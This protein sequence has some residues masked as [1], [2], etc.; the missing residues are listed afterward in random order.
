M[1]RPFLAL[2]HNAA[3]VMTALGMATCLIIW[4]VV[5]K[6][7]E[8]STHLPIVFYILVALSNSRY[9]FVLARALDVVLPSVVTIRRNIATLTSQKAEEEERAVDRPLL[10]FEKGSTNGGPKVPSHPT[11]TIGEKGSY[12]V[13]L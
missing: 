9:P 4:S 3:E 10:I 12:S 6:K 7:E 5:A 8:R 13:D 11:D 1:F 2:T